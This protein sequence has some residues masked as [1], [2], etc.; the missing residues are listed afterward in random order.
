MK[1]PD[2]LKSK[3]LNFTLKLLRNILLK[4]KSS[5]RFRGLNDSFK[6]DYY[7]QTQAKIKKREKN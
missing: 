5:E 2:K 3:K 6:S 1:I 7:E 4:S